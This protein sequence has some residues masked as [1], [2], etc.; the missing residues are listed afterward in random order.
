M[1]KKAGD[2]LSEKFGTEVKVG[3]IN[4]GL[5]NRVIVDDVRMKDQSGQWVRTESDT[6][7]AT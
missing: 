3:R 2:L 1:G 5:F 4:I 7:E 6:T